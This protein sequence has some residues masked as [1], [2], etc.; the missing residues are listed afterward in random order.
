MSHKQPFNESQYVPGDVRPPEQ[1][2]GANTDHDL[3][4]ALGDSDH[5]EFQYDKRRAGRGFAFRY[6]DPASALRE[7]IANAETAGIRR[8]RCELEGE[9]ADLSPTELIECARNDTGYLPVIE[10]HHAHHESDKPTLTIADNGVGISIEE[11]RVL[12]KIGLSTSHD[13]GDE[14]GM[15][16]QGVMSGFNFVG[17]N[18]RL[19]L[20]T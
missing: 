7:Y 8:C 6:E 9:T 20:T 3:K 13:K 11:F 15:F 16:G 10:V 18:G 17:E 1:V 5:R 19:G 2:D 14:S 12:R 4:E